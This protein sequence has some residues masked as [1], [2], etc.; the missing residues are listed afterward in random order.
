MEI[1]ALKGFSQP[2]P[3]KN[4]NCY[5]CSAFMIP[6]ASKQRIASFNAST[7]KS[8]ATVFKICRTSN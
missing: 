8:P 6:G 7:Q 2:V 5:L 1:L 4:V 3:A